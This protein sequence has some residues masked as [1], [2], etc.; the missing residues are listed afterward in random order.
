MLVVSAP[1]NFAVTGALFT[2]TITLREHGVRPGMI[3]LAQGIIG[4][5][6]LLGALAA[7]RIARRVT[8]RFL[9]VATSCALA[10]CFAVAGLLT[11]SVLMAVP[12]TCGLVLS[13]AANAMLFGRLAE[14]TPAR[15]QARV[16]S[17]VFF[18][19]TTAASLAPFVSG[20]LIEHV[21]GQT[22]MELA[23]LA[24][25]GSALAAILSGGL[26]A[27]PPVRAAAPDLA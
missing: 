11:T 22:A 4:V 21:T 9:V 24:A 13:P 10:L 14:T 15:L 26:R 12:I 25:A 16:V 19:A 6:G 5:G 18:V 27:S 3:G 8:L 23:A 20:V 7:P 17:V 2:M 1:L